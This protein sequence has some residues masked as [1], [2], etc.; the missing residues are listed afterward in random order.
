MEHFSIIYHVLKSEPFGSN[1]I[2]NLYMMEPVKVVHTSSSIK[3]LELGVFEGSKQ[4]ILT[5]HRSICDQSGSSLAQ[6]HLQIRTRITGTAREAF[7]GEFFFC[8][9]G[10][11]AA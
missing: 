8:Y 9:C 11:F 1:F 10:Y 6:G 3:A 5:W 4:Y 7:P 2:S